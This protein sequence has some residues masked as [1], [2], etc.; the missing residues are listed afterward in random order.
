VDIAWA[1]TQELPQAIENSDVTI[2]ADST[3]LTFTMGSVAA[4][5]LKQSEAYIST[6]ALF[7]VF[8]NSPREEK[9]NLRLPAVWRDLWSEL[10][11][12]KKI[13]SDAEERTVVKGLR[14]LIRQ[15]L[16]QELED[17][18]ILQGAFRGRGNNKSLTESTD[19]TGQGRSKQD[20]GSNDLMRTIWA[21]K[22]G[23]RK[24]QQMLVC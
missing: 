10:A 21:E 23:S 19:G 6:V 18:V 20:N 13:F 2:S 24:Y 3:R 15:R 16:D 7:Y 11:E 8:S 17:G 9:V 4:P 14:D 5:D 1:K 22:S 12:A